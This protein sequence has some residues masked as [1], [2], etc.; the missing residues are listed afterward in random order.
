MRIGNFQV[1]TNDF[2]SLLID[3]GAMFGSVPKTIWGKWIDTDEHNRARLVTRSLVIKS[4]KRTFL[5]DAGCGPNLPIKYVENFVIDN[6]AQQQWTFKPEE[7]TDIIVTHL[8]FD[9]CGWLFG[10]RPEGEQELHPL[11]PNAQIYL[12]LDNYQTALR[13]TL[14][15]RAS[16]LREQI[17]SLSG[18]NVT[19]LDGDSELIPGLSVHSSSGHTG[20]LQWVKID[21][22][23]EVLAFPGD[24][25]PSAHHLA[26]SYTTGYDIWVD[27]LL[28]EKE[29][30]L[31][32]AM[33]QNWLLVFQHDPE[34]CAAR[35]TRNDKGHYAVASREQL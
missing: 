3:G 2:G 19:M 30:I 13:P 12:Q 16:Y 14:K 22:E 11:F 23:G 26:L 34:T 24:L 4:D 35:I 32:Q 9:H 1:W 33:E 6:V 5:I 7:I 17:D 10:A 8:H 15:E 20:G 29:L 18:Y 25:I 27:R 21:G 31:S 28:Q